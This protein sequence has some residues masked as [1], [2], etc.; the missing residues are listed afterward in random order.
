[1]YAYKSTIS[2][3]IFF[4]DMMVYKELCGDSKLCFFIIKKALG[5]EELDLYLNSDTYWMCELG[6]LIQCLCLEL[7]IHKMGS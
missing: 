3:W 6:C 5:T 1:M 4:V 7:L 2:L